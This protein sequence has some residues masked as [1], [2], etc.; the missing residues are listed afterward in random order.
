M[1]EGYGSSRFE[2]DVRSADIT[3]EQH[4]LQDHVVFLAPRNRYY[5]PVLRL[6]PI[7]LS[8]EAGICTS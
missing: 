5:H 4:G 3:H 2:I 7:E 8:R 1:L 6:S